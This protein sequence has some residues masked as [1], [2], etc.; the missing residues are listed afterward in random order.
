M[1]WQA[2][3]KIGFGLRDKFVVAWYC[4][5]KGN[6]G[7]GNAAAT[8]QNYKDNVKKDCVIDGVDQCYNDIA[9]KA[10]NT[11]RANHKGGKALLP[12]LEA[13]K[14]IQARLNAAG[15]D[16]DG[17]IWSKEPD[18]TFENC[19][20]NV[21]QAPSSSTADLEAT[22]QTAIAVD[23]WYGGQAWYDFSTGKPREVGDAEKVKLSN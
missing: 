22:R 4:D 9:L 2:T 14:R 6:S 19:A 5:A 7:P 10:H 17:S 13:S 23:T 18:R 15:S 1:T 16:F 21:Y 20:E 8:T 12:Y 11:A 3:K